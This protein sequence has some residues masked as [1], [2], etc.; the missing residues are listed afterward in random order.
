MTVCGGCAQVA[1]D[2]RGVASVVQQI[3][4]AEGI[5]GLYG[6]VR[7]SMLKVLPMAILSFGTYEFVRMHLNRLADAMEE[8]QVKNERKRCHLEGKQNCSASQR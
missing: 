2:R 7:A 4:R 1:T 8:E 6:G 5:G 3:L